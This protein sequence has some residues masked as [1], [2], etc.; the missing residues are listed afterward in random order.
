MRRPGLRLLA[1]DEPAAIGGDHLELA[2]R[3]H[4]GS[5]HLAGSSCLPIGS[6]M[7]DSSFLELELKLEELKTL[8]DDQL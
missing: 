6:Q 4:G 5:L 3:N 8:V 1:G 7:G 2:R